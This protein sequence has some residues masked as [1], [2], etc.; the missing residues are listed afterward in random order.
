[1]CRKT[2]GKRTLN[3][4]VRTSAGVELDPGGKKPGRGAYLCAEPSCWQ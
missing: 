2:D 1:M 4:I 3:R